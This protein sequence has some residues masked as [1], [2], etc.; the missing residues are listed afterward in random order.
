M[1]RRIEQADRHGQPSHG[2]EDALEV[3]LLMRQQLRERL[4]ALVLARGHDHRAD[5]WEP[6]LGHEHVL[7]AAQADPLRAELAR[8]RR[9][10]RACRRSRAPRRRRISSAQP[11][12]ALEVLVHLRSDEVDLADD[13]L[14]RA[15]VD[16]DHVAL[17]ELLRRRS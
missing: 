2:L 1:Q 5:E 10:L 6:V 11:E 13:H 7:G 9:V 17:G 3:L 14:A 15:A 12:Q 8:L 4:A 16:R